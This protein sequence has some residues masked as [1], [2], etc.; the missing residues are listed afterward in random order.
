MWQVSAGVVLGWSLGSN[1]AANVFG[2]AVT[3]RMVRFRTAA[4]L[5]SGFVILGALLEGQ[6]GIETYNKMS[7]LTSEAAFC[8]SLGA[9]LT[10]AMMSWI[11]L[12]VSTSQA[13]VGALVVVGYMESEVHFASLGKVVACWVGTPIGAALVTVVLY[14]VLGGIMNRLRP[15]LFQYD[16]WLRW[17]LVAAGSYGSYALG[18]N[19]VANVTGPFVGSGMLTP[20]QACAIGSVAISIGVVTFS[21][22]VMTTVGKDIVPLDAF[23]ALVAILSEAI[24]VHF[25]AVLGVPVSTSQAIVGAVLGIGLVKGAQMVNRGTLVKIT[26]GWIGTP[27][28]AAGVAY[29]LYQGLLY[30]GVI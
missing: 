29:L 6:A 21:Y 2:T 16:R 14:Y 26:F 24:T 25:Y 13:I 27:I 22:R 10:V 9:A 20:L 19:N 3:S 30:A 17:G 15:T 8:A 28:I 4:I 12:P 7:T 23:T 18:A 11:G 5:C 1:D